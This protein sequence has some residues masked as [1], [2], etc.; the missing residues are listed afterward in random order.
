MSEITLPI[1]FTSNDGVGHLSDTIVLAPGN[2]ALLLVDCDGDCGERCN[3][4]IHDHISPALRAARL[5][6]IQ[7]IFIYC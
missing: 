4:V 5:A 2:S 7:P 6:G 3:R 1:R